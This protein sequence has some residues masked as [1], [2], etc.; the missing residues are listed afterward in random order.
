MP[1]YEY[2]C[3]KCGRQ[4]EELVFGQASPPCP[5]CKSKKTAKLMIR[6]RA[7]TGGPKFPATDLAPA[8]AR[9]AGSGCAGCAGGSC[10]TCG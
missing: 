7:K 6:C 4:F 3:K 5:A 8:P 1:I 2:E 10:S 9:S